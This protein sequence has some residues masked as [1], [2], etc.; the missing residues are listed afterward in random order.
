MKE[1]L[2]SYLG[3]F[4][5]SV[6]LALGM[7]LL[8]LAGW[9]FGRTPLWFDLLCAVLTLLPFWV[10]GVLMGRWAKRKGRSGSGRGVAI[11]IALMAAA[12]LVMWR[13]DGSWL[14]V[15]GWPG[16]I[17]GHLPVEL[18]HLKY[19]LWQYYA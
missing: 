17:A 8:G 15:L 19:Y 11:L 6:A 16:M 14:Y 2:L 3:A 4:A 13:L 12:G 10:I 18:F 9:F 1:Y 7:M 5:V